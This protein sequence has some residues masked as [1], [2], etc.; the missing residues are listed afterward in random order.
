MIETA[1]RTLP[2]AEGACLLSTVTISEPH[3]NGPEQFDAASFAAHSLSSPQ[4]LA[5]VLDH[6]LVKP[7]VTRNKVLELCSEAAQY[8][9]ACATV[10]PCW[11]SLAVA[12]LKGTGIP[13]GVVI[14][15]PLGAN[16]SGS[17]KTEAEEVLKLGAHDI[18]MVLNIGLLK[19]GQAGDYDAV[20][21]DIRDV[22][23]QAHDHGAIVK[24]VLETC[25]LAFEEKL[26]GAELALGAG[27]D[28]L[29]TS[30]GFSTG[31]ATE[32]DIALL[33]STYGSRAGVKA[34]GGIRSLADAS[35][36]LKA[37]ASRIGASASVKIIS[38]LAIR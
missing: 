8:R 24:V 25:L 2:T 30:T 34:S 32:D 9:F 29:Q 22:V 27:A 36:M 31:G 23:E 3:P 26:R 7:D 17:K 14:G 35:A 33:R 5:A 28:F 38:E 11:V 19:S 18:D 1:R 4:S 20:R 6:S 16:L 12:A 15:F 21:Q 37:G 13:V 10:N